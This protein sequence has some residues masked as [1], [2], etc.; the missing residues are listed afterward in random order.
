VDHVLEFVCQHPAES[1]A[2]G[3]AGR[4]VNEEDL[5]PFDSASSPNPW[6]FVVVGVGSSPAM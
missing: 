4:N 1:D 3:D 6:V 2:G 5:F